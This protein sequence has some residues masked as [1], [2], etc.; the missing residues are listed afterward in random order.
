MRKMRWKKKFEKKKNK[1][2]SL[3]VVCVGDEVFIFT[4]WDIKLV[5]F[6]LYTP[7]LMN[8]LIFLS[9]TLLNMKNGR[10]K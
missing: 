3:V 6:N 10:K 2:K 1:K 4:C 8:F 5:N 9:V 7:P